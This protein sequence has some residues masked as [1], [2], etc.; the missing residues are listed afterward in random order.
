MLRTPRTSQCSRC[1]G[2]GHRD[3]KCRKTFKCR[4]CAEEHSSKQYKCGTCESTG[5]YVYVKAKCLNCNGEHTADSKDC[6][7]YLAIRNDRK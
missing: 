4:L 3:V 2:F 7:I 6:K 1:L 5:L